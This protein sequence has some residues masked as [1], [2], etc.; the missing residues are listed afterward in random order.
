M[1]TRRVT[2]YATVSS[3]LID[4]L[5]PLLLTKLDM[6]L[7][8]WGIRV[9]PPRRTIS[10]TLPLLILELWRIVEDLLNGLESGMEEILAE[11][12][13]T[14]TGEGGVEI[15]TLVERVDFNGSL[16]HRRKDAHGTLA[17]AETTE[18]T[19]VR[20]EILLH[21]A[22]ELL[23]EVVHEAVVE[24]LTTQ[25]SITGGGLD[26]EDTLLNCEEWHIVPRQDRR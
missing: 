26:L 17:R 5:G 13:K 23:E 15:D 10:Y 8:M 21:L 16:S 2:P 6:I 25:V 7:T 14:R 4:L 11:L 1:E 12:L 20:Q 22:I 24:V 9:E 18:G 3:K 19:S